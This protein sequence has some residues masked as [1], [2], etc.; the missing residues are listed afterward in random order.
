METKKIEFEKLRYAYI[1]I[2]H[3]LETETYEKINSLND[4]IEKDLALSGDD[5]L[6]LLEKFVK[7]FELDHKGFNYS[8]YFLSEGE[9]FDPGAVIVNLLA[10]SV[11]LPLKTIELLTLNKI[12]LDKPKLPIRPDRHVLDLTFKDL[13]TWY[14][15]KEFKTSAEIKYEIV[16]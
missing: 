8:K 13:I 6:E 5:N 7:K 1:T 10:V 16:K 9:L 14:L 15:E 4:K 11:W 12:N 2:K 3:F